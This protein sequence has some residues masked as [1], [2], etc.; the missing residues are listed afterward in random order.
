MDAS[1][2]F[3]NT[4]KAATKM[5]PSLFWRHL[6]IS[7]AFY[8]SYWK[9]IITSSH[10]TKYVSC[11]EHTENNPA[12][13]FMEGIINIKMVTAKNS[14]NDFYRVSCLALLNHVSQRIYDPINCRM[15]RAMKNIFNNENFVTHEFRGM[16]RRRISN[17]N[18]SNTFYRTLVSVE[19]REDQK[20]LVTD[21]AF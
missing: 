12:K 16:P 4:L 1:D 13:Y 9:I 6:K 21:F 18:K 17:V 2:V 11:K 7:G 20:E 5:I 10:F 15:Y 14:A 3:K 19:H 8:R